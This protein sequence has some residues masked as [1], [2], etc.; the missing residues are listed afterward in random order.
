MTK[1]TEKNLNSV[2]SELSYKKKQKNKTYNV[3]DGMKFGMNNY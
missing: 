1:M 2:E 3:K